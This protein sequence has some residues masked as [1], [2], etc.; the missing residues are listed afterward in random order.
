MCDI[1]VPTCYLTEFRHRSSIFCNGDAG[2]NNE[3][4]WDEIDAELQDIMDG[5]RNS[6]T[7]QV[8]KLMEDMKTWKYDSQSSLSPDQ[9]V[10]EKLRLELGLSPSRHT[11]PTLDQ[12]YPSTPTK[13][14][15]GSLLSEMTRPPSPT[16]ICDFPF[17]ELEGTVDCEKFILAPST[18]TT[19]PRF[20]VNKQ[21]IQDLRYQVEYA[22]APLSSWF[23]K[24]LDT[25]SSLTSAPMAKHSRSRGL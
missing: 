20:R 12:D 22:D 11:K 9:Q 4:E 15:P 16:N 3:H 21:T 18:E 2:I 19:L 14:P 17:F 13:P 8:H 25:V 1:G 24:F 10:M 7:K 23:P 6:P 5:V